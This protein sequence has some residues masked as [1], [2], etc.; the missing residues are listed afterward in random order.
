MQ[1]T[2][3]R[4]HLTELLVGESAHVN[5]QTAFARLPAA[6]R[7][8]APP[9]FPHTAWELLEHLRL[10]QRDIL[11][12]LQNPRYTAPPFPEGY[13]PPTPAPP[14]PEAWDASLRAFLEDLEALR[15]LVND[16]SVDLFAHP[17]PAPAA[18]T[19]VREVLVVAAHNAYHLGQVVALRRAQGAWPP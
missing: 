12:Y 14:T 18:P 4:Q 6:L 19:L 1:E 7:G 17:P 8:Q 2:L 9:G 13:W 11:E 16:P 15:R 10:A 3:L 5:A